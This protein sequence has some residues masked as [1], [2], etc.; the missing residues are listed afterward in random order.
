MLIDMKKQN[1]TQPVVAE[2]ISSGK[3]R[4][5]FNVETKTRS[6]PTT[7]VTETYYNYEY[8]E[9]CVPITK[10]DITVQIIRSKYGVDDE[11][12]FINNNNKGDTVSKAEYKAY[13]DF[14]QY[15]KNVATSALQIINT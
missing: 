2:E 4:I 13:Q 3:W 7:A 10:K 6:H 8:V 15:A 14:R 5:H 1:N 9:L 11:L 12:S